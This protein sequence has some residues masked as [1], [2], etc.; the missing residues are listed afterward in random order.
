MKFELLLP[1][2]LLILIFAPVLAWFIWDGIRALRKKQRP[3]QGHT[4]WRLVGISICLALIAIGSSIPG[5]RAPAGVINL[6]VVLVVDRTASISAE[7]Y[8]GQKP[9][10]EGVKSDL[11][12]LIDRVK[13]ARIALV[14]FDTSARINVPFTS[15]SSAAATAIK[16]LD[17]EVSIYS[18]GSSIDMP[19]D[20][21]TKL[22]NQS[23]Q[24]Y[25][26]RGRL[27]FYAG[28]GEQTADSTPKSFTSIKP[29]I[30]GGAVLGYGTSAGGKMKTYY[31]YQGY[32]YDGIGSEYLEDLTAYSA[33]GYPLA[34]SRIDETNLKNIANDLGVTYLHRTTASQPLNEVVDGSKLKVVGDTH[35]EVLHYVSLYWIFAAVIGVLL[36]WWLLDLSKPLRS[37]LRKEGV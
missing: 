12:Q 23:K 11:L 15:D 28:D 13:G 6:D 9:R 30:N 34:V 27:V 19:I 22:L 32:G 4:Y 16:A 24:K 20:M 26:D 3:F 36:L 21:I 8:D 33:S 14:T 31:G 25:P 17:Q 2:W 7:D 18:K 10:L 1:W 5:D 29:L 35:R 37:G